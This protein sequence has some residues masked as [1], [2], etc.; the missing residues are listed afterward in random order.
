MEYKAIFG[1]FN[2]AFWWFGVLS[3]EN[4]HGQPFFNE[5]LILRNNVI[6][7]ANLQTHL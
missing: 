3:V 1:G 5:K 6:Y 2:G 4:S 7:E